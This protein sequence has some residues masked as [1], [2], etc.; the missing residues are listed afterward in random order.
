MED[1]MSKD[2]KAR[3]K[4][5]TIVPFTLTSEYYFAKG[6]KSYQKQEYH[7]AKRYLE[8]AEMLEPD[9]PMISFQL[10]IVLTEAG[11]FKESNQI[12]L[13]V[14][15]ESDGNMT[16]CHYFLAN[17]YAHLG[18]FKEAYQHATAYLEY[19]EDGVF[20]EDTEDLLDLLRLED[21]EIEEE[22]Y[23]HDEL[24][25]KQEHARELLETGQFE[26]AVES[27]Q[28]IVKEYPEYWSAHNNLA[29]A[30]FYLGKEKKADDILNEV[31]EKNP[32]NLHALCNKLVFAY[33][34]MDYPAVRH[35]KD[36]LVKVKPMLVEQK[37]KL[38]ATLA[39]VGEHDTAYSL[40]KHLHKQGIEGEGPFYYWLCQ[41]AY[42]SGREQEARKYWNKVLQYDPEKAGH[43]PWNKEGSSLDG[44]E[45][46]L[47]DINKKI[48]SN[49]IE[50][51]LFGLFL[52]SLSEKKD[53][54]LSDYCAQSELEEQYIKLLKENLETGDSAI[55]GAHEAAEYLYDF[56][57]PVDSVESG[58]F[59][60]WFSLLVEM[61]KD[62]V[63][64]KN[65]K[66]Y[67][68]AVEYLWRKLRNEKLSQNYIAKQYNLSLSTMRKYV[69][70]VNKY[71]Q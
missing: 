60:M 68:A 61:E 4:M 33:Y 58:V 64:V 21:G 52:T 71:L 36:M 19:D 44:I 54:I 50:E 15:E 2:S 32:G 38:G 65:G 12:F 11:E 23:E 14:L 63:S 18:L 49:H 67:A 13:K 45:E 40:L 55:D 46:S 57:H 5:G 10:G 25:I 39:L 26:E 62:H 29:L 70:I 42:Y 59:L 8:R 56:H 41:S 28:A 9:E 30:N 6:L 37:F 3:Q 51:R 48:Q 1:F 22:L 27:L 43:E 16:E 53:E 34:S 35:Y 20:S 17:N 69:K 31:L 7:K 24:I 66:A 47:L